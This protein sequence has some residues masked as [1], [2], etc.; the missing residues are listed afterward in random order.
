MMYGTI[1]YSVAGTY[2]GLCIAIGGFECD[3]LLII[4]RS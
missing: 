3:M 2:I 1:Y 4:D